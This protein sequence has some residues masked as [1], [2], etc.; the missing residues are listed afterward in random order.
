[1]A[2]KRTTATPDVAACTAPASKR[3]RVKRMP[4][5][6]LDKGDEETLSPDFLWP[7]TAH[8]A[9]DPNRILLR[10]IFFIDEDKTKYV[11][12]VLPS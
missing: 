10:R 7:T 3:R 9:F 1:M 12:R 8:P 2:T 6:V 4:D 11:S 5:S